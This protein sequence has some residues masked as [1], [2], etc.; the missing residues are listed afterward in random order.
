[1]KKKKILLATLFSILSVGLFSCGGSKSKS[2]NS[3]EASLSKEVSSSET[4]SSS[5]LESKDENSKSEESESNIESEIESEESISYSISSVD[6]TPI[7]DTNVLNTV[8]EDFNKVILPK[9]YTSVTKDS[10]TQSLKLDFNMQQN[11]I[12]NCDCIEQVGFDEID[13]NK[14]DY[15]IDYDKT[16]SS[17]GSYFG[18]VLGCLISD[19]DYYTENLVSYENSLYKSCNFS[20]Y[21]ATFNKNPYYIIQVEDSNGTNMDLIVIDKSGLASY[22]NISN[23]YKIYETKLIDKGTLSNDDLDILN[24]EKVIKYNN[25][26]CNY[27]I[28]NKNEVK[29]LTIPETYRTIPFTNFDINELYECPL[30][31]EIKVPDNHSKYKTVD[32]ILYSKNMKTLL[33]YPKSKIL[34][35]YVIPESVVSINDN[36]LKN[37]K[38]VKSLVLSDNIKTINDNQFENSNFENVIISNNCTKIGKSIFK[39]CANLSTLTIPF[40]GSDIDN[41]ENSLYLFDKENNDSMNQY[42]FDNNL[43]YISNIKEINI[44]NSISDNSFVGLENSL[45]K[46]VLPESLTKI[47]SNLLNL[48]FNNLKE[49]ISSGCKTIDMDAFVK[50]VNLESLDASNVEVVEENAFKNLTKLSNIDLSNAKTIKANAFNGC[51]SIESVSALKLQLLGE[52]A[53]KDCTNLSSIVIDNVNEIGSYALANTKISSININNCETIGSSVF[54]G[55]TQ[56]KALTLNVTEYNPLILNESYINTLTLNAIK[57][58]TE[59]AFKDNTALV[60]I[61]L[62]LA[63]SIGSFAFSNMS[64]LT[65]VSAANVTS[66]DSYA[67]YNSK[68]L[69]TFNAGKITSLGINAFSNTKIT[70]FDLN[71]ITT[72]PSYCFSGCTELASITGNITTVG[73]NA[74]Y[75]CS[76]LKTITLSSITTIK[77]NGFYGCTSLPEVINMANVKTLESG[78]FTNC[79]QITQISFESLT[80]LSEGVFSGCTGLKSITSLGN[81][82]T[83]PSQSFNNCKSLSSVNLKNITTI[84]SSAF[85]GCTSLTQLSNTSKVRTVGEKAFKNCGLQSLSMSYLITVEKEAFIGNTNLKTINAINLSFIGDYAFNE[86]TNLTTVTLSN[87]GETLGKYA[88]DG[89]TSLNSLTFGFRDIQDYAFRN[90]TSLTTVSSSFTEGVGAFAFNNCTKLSTLNMPNVKNIYSSAFSGCESLSNVTITSVDSVYSSAFENCAKYTNISLPYV[91]YIGAYAFNGIK[92]SSFIVPNLKKLSDYVYDS[93]ASGST[94]EMGCTSVNTYFRP[95]KFSYLSFPNVT[96]IDAKNFASSDII[97]IDAPKCTEIQELAFRYCKKLTTVNFPLVT[98][99]GQY[100]FDGSTVTSLSFPNATS[101]SYYSFA[102]NTSLTK[103]EL[104]LVTTIPSYLCI[105]CTNLESYSAPKATTIKS[106]A[107]K[108]CKSL[109]AISSVVKIVEDG[110]FRECTSLKS[111]PT[112]LESVGQNGFYGCTGL[113]SLSQYTCPYLTT[114]GVSAF[115]GCTGF[116]TLDLTKVTSIGREAF[117]ACSNVTR[118]DLNGSISSVGLESFRGLTQLSQVVITGGT[119]IYSSFTSVEN[120]GYLLEYPSVIVCRVPKTVTTSSSVFSGCILVNTKLYSKSSEYIQNSLDQLISFTK[121]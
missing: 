108:G 42:E 90:C 38:F 13:D 65:K 27:E 83:I 97:S 12:D 107:F 46:I 100:A 101:V 56:L 99:I 77:T 93:V 109:K 80:S 69:T 44:T 112:N 92:I 43:Y 50:C 105:N 25:N 28:K 32:G 54:S 24:L 61:N 9:T 111:L 20:Y 48:N 82:T 106:F 64:K 37:I 62:P 87:S 71:S 17:D 79:S 49:V 117:K 95:T 104:P 75:G 14:V 22:I 114:I 66:V 81:I 15:L 70:S 30:L 85:E 33:C 96:A 11:L 72:V 45:E 35:E 34:D 88:F 115:Y 103:I 23:G 41:L 91:T 98:T 6:I 63:T 102:N 16:E 40:I 60:E 31:E 4:N 116:K 94:L 3:I 74:F 78:A 76:K 21:Y 118:V 121:K 36:A 7:E 1:M 18:N 47:S 29:S 59:N 68:A 110:A 119:N 58:V 10:I 84:N 39:N 2:S 53:F 113:T 19:F 57:N 89:C 5:E 52:S 26:G 55:V 73:T 8:L 120:S 51:K 86:L 67:F